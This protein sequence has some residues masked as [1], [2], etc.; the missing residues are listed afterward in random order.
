MPFLFAY[1]P[2]MTL[3]IDAGGESRQSMGDPTC[4]KKEFHKQ[5]P[6][7]F[8]SP[9]PLLVKRWQQLTYSSFRKILWNAS[10]LA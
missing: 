10:G 2:A 6:W 8:L 9:G 5:G 4:L 1:E 3:Y 7:K